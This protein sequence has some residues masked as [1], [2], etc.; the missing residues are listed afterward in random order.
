MNLTKQ[1]VTDFVTALRS[2]AIGGF[3]FGTLLWIPA[4]AFF[5]DSATAE[6]RV[7]GIAEH[8]S[9]ED[10]IFYAPTFTFSD[11]QGIT[12]TVTSSIAF[13]SPQYRRG[14]TIKVRYR[15]DAPS[16]ARIDDFFTIWGLPM[17][18]QGGCAVHILLWSAIL[19]FLRGR[20]HPALF[21]PKTRRPNGLDSHKV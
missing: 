14:Q 6:G 13:A 7:V 21:Q 8:S 3:A 16:D 12:H 17:T 2:L 11:T 1:K 5:R 4:G 20:S 15:I 18:V 9:S 19:F 10:G